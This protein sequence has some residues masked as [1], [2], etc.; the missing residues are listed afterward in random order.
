MFDVADIA[1][2]ILLHIYMYNAITVYGTIC[3]ASV[4]MI[5]TVVGV[6]SSA[7]YSRCKRKGT[8]IMSKTKL[9]EVNL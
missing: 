9:A 2:C 1:I 3:G 5:S 6:V 8:L 4:L 7:M